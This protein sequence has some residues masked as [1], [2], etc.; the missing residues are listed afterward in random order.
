MQ[1]SRR[2]AISKRNIVIGGLSRIGLSRRLDNLLRVCRIWLLVPTLLTLSSLALLVGHYLLDGTDIVWA[3]LLETLEV[4][5]FD[6]LRQRNLPRL[7]P[8]IGL[9]SELLGIHPKFSRHLYMG[10]GKAEPL[11]GIDPCLEFGR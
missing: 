5:L 2:L 7:L 3:L 4:Q 10:V 1:A 6:V 8:V 9:A 11:S